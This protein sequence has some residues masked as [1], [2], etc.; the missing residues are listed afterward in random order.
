MMRLRLLT[1]L[2]L[3]VLAGT[4]GLATADGGPIM[5]L[6][7]V[8]PG[9]ACTAYTVV[10]GTTISSFDVQIIG[11]VQEAG[12]GARILVRVSGPAVAQ[13]GIA[14]GF[15]GSPVYCPDT[16]GT[17]ENIGAISESVGQ[18]GNDVGLVTPIEQMLGEP[19]NPPSSAPLLRARARPLVGP[20]TVSGLSPALLEVLQQAGARAGR[21]IVDAPSGPGLDFPVQPLIPGASVAVSYSEGAITLGAVGTVTYRDAQ[22][23]YAFGHEL[24]GAGAR[25]L[26]LQDAYVNDVIDNPDPTLQPSYKLA[27]PGHTEGALTSD[28]PN[29]VIGT[30]GAPPS[31]IPVNVT[32]TDLDTGQVLNLDSEVADETDLGFPLGT[33]LIDMVAPLEVSQAATEIYNGPPAD[34]SGGMC[35]EVTLRE[36]P[37]PLRFCNRYAGTGST[38]T[39]LAPPELASA[40]SADV[41]TALGL[42]DAVQFARLHVT[43]VSAQIDAQRGLAQGWI[44]SAQ[45]PLEV[46]AGH[47]VEVRL[48]VRLYRA[49]LRTLSF[50]LQIPPAMRGMVLA[51]VK[52]PTPQ[53]SS[54]SS[55]GSGSSLGSTLEQ[56]LTGSTPPGPGPLSITALGHQFGGV[57]RYD[58]LRLSLNGKPAT[59]VF[60]DPSLLIFG[61]AE[62]AFL[63]K[64]P[65]R[66]AR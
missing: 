41:T 9:M 2:A 45:A 32:A 53:S 60:R 20:L 52:G 14:E 48:L 35:F 4:P 5:P 44:V 62:L 37:A 59:D 54:S 6:S 15:S 65:A 43:S 27:S 8:Q 55:G 7:Q 34:E 39:L 64:A 1:P 58:G 13:S 12:Q 29:A 50:H 33:S 66:A 47:S 22:T 24:D 16:L 46:T 31:L 3:A 56:L 36:T 18:Y 42:L 61:N 30:V 21:Q 25:S 19:V 51:E 63:V 38:G 57:G 11:V 17:P 23:V 49:G 26:L 28:T 10:Q 40:T